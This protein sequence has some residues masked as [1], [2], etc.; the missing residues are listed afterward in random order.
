M[1]SRRVDV[2]YVFFEMIE[3]VEVLFVSL[4]EGFVKDFWF[5]FGLLWE[6]CLIC[7]VFGE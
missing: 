3:D 7:E 2:F 1:V 6:Y 5:G 4:F